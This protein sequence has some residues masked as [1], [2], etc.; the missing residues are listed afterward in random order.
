MDMQLFAESD[1]FAFSSADPIP[2]GHRITAF[3]E[4]TMEDG[5]VV[6]LALLS[7]GKQQ[8][9]YLDDEGWKGDSFIVLR[10]WKNEHN[11]FSH[12]AVSVEEFQ[13]IVGQ[14]EKSIT[15]ILGA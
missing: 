5:E 15:D 9:I 8:R 4:P 3:G 13:I 14:I 11:R 7:S 6:G 10:H 2:Y 1:L 12:E